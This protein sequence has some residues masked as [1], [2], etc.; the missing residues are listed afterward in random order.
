M[1]LR[2]FIDRITKPVDERTLLQEVERVTNGMAQ[3]PATTNRIG[4]IHATSRV[5]EGSTFAVTL[6]ALEPSKAP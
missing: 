1:A 5:G 3:R 6:P 2:R 4:T